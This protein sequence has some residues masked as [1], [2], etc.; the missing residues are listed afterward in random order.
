[1][2]HPA[3][4]LA[5]RR[6]LLSLLIL[7]CALAVIVGGRLHAADN[8]VR[9]LWVV[10]TTLTSPAA[11]EAMV[12][13]ARD[14]GFNTLLVQVRGRGDAF[15]A[16]RI[17][18]R[19]AQLP[20]Q[21]TF[22][23]LAET[24]RLAHQAGLRVHAWVNVNLISNVGELPAAR[25][26]VIYRHPEWLMVPSEIAP[27]LVRVNPR[28]PEYLERLVQYVRTQLNEI[29][30]LYVSPLNPDAA[31]Y[32]VSVIRDIVR[33]YPV[34]GIHLDYIRYPRDDFDYSPFALAA[35]RR[36]AL[37]DLSS[38]DRRR[39]DDRL[40]DEP[41]IYTQAFPER[42]HMFREAHLTRLVEQIRR[43][44]KSARSSAL[45]SA[46]VVP[47]HNE[48]AAQR[49]QNWRLWLD[50]DLLDVICPMAYTIDAGRFVSQVANVRAIAG[51]KPVWAGIGAY[52]LTSPQ[53][54]AN[55]QA[56]RKLGADGVVLFSYDSL[57]D[58]AHGTDYLAQVAREAFVP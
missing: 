1:M 35:F 46:A 4:V 30:G 41:L 20:P 8:D 37:R 5:T 33:R 34:D 52:R 6:A 58:P 50:R 55:V 10:R 54:A 47:D 17:E 3:R 28:R 18:A 24:L 49:M 44:V 32:T 36:D 48:A 40:R 21:S 51:S 19:A 11:I 25:D 12:R 45:L 22:D 43:A 42:W 27:D 13:T 56:A 14:A 38:A 16:S 2:R 39:Y 26:H 9:A 31:D 23:P 29:E 7:S 15:Y 57:I 53:I